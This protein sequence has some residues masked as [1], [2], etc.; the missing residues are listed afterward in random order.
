MIV[1]VSRYSDTVKAAEPRT[2]HCI[3]ST[4]PAWTGEMFIEAIYADLNVRSA[5]VITS[6]SAS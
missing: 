3:C 1:V 6:W 5:S 2:N 4:T